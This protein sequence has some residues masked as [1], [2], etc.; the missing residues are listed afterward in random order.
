[1]D[2]NKIES[3]TSQLLEDLDKV[4]QEAEQLL[5]E[6]IQNAKN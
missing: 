6:E 4:E 5:R 1:M 2:L 3:I